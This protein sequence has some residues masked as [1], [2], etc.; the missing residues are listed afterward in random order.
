MPA[1]PEMGS[2]W[3]PW[4]SAVIQVITGEDTPESAFSTA[5]RQIRDILGGSMAGMVNVPGSY[6][7][8]VGC[9]SEWDSACELTV[10]VEG[11][12]GLWTASHSLLA[13][14]FEA[15]VA[16]DGAWTVNY[17]VDG[18][19]DGPN[20]AFSLAA[21]GTVTFAYDPRTH[22]QTITVEYP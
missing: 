20:Y 5:A 21:P 10:L 12:D 7:P 18:V 2:V 17:G 4:N 16:L 14:D 6:Q 9:E 3:G 11:A 19:P 13:G 1:I 15:K 22:I 8:A